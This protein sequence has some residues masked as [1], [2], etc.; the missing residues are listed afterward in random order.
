[1]RCIEYKPRMSKQTTWANYG[2][3][4]V[5]NFTYVGSSV[6]TACTAQGVQ[7]YGYK[8]VYNFIYVGSSVYTACTAQVVQKYGYKWVYNSIYVGSSVYTAC[9]LH[10]QLRLYKIMDI[11]EFIT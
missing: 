5:Y 10:V 7:N 3:K 4:W 9:T 8:W 11:S 6:Y 1:M 2:Y